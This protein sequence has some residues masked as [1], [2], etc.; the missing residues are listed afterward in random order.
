[1]REKINALVINSTDSVAVVIEPLEAGEAAT[2]KVNGKEKSI[3]VKEP[4]P[5]YHKIALLDME[6]GQGLYKYGEKIGCALQ[7][8]QAGQHVHTHNLV[9]IR[10][11]IKNR[12]E[13]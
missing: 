7:A 4:I 12:K 13:F 2:Y 5:I 11:T 3:A 6:K 1:M 8:I 10:E 9:S